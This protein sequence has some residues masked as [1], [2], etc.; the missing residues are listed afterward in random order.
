MRSAAL[1]LLLAV[2]LLVAGCKEAEMLGGVAQNLNLGGTQVGSIA[3]SVVVSGQAVA[4]SMEDF[5]P[6]QE[7]YIGRAVTAS[8][9]ERYRSLNDAGLNSYVNTLGQ[10][11]AMSSTM[12]MTYAGYH[13]QVVDADEI[14]A[15]AA[16]GGF[17]L[18]TRGLI[19]CCPNETALAGV[20]A[21]EIAHVQNKDAL[22]AI[23]KSRVTQALGV[24]GTETAK[25]LAGGQLAQL[26]GIF[27]D[28]VGDI[29]TSMVNN[30]YSRSYEYEADQ[31]A[32]GILTRSGYD[33]AGLA[34]ML[35]TMQAR[36]KPGGSD[37]AKTHP[38]PADR[39]DKLGAVG[40]R[41]PAPEPAPRTARFGQSVGA[42]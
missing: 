34:V 15:F 39:L 19:R 13:F 25:H 6:E 36:L 10:A 41:T 16:P 7:Y 22:R 2:V 24:I 14:N 29:M 26:T 30:G 40:G 37:F 33:P 18:V 9:L 31:G 21:H 38:A 4:K 32:V 20:L 8:L 35:R 12:P 42:I 1:V 5:T 23:N 27:A 11:L 3:Q 28:S 17:I